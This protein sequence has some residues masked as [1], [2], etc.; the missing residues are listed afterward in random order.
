MPAFAAQAEEFSWQLSGAKRQAESNVTDSDSW[1]VD[2]TWYA[3]PIDDSEGPYALA[4]FL[5]PTTRVSAAASGGDSQD[6]LDDPTAYTLNGAYVLP[7][8]KWYV[9]AEYSKANVD[10]EP[11]VTF[12]D[13]KGYGVR[14]G[15]YLGANTTLEVGMGR[16]EQESSLS[17]GPIPQLCLGIPLEIELTTD[18]VD[19][20]VFYVRRFRSLTYSL[21]GRVS[22]RE[23]EVEF[24]PSLLPGITQLA[25]GTVRQYSV[26]AELFPNQRLGVRLGYSQPEDFD[27]ESYDISATWFFKPR[28]AVQFSLAESSVDDAVPGVGRSE[29]LGVRFVGRL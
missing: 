14:A 25:G 29:S 2:A 16:S 17:C 15:R 10:D 20:E 27:A 22:E 19:L 8:Q 5:N 4:S 23:T 12:S 9:G 7:S 26:A 3:E 21:Q 28:I 6:A 1:A 24:R 18:S 13:P 11:P